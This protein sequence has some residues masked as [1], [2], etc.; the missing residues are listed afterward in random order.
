M[1]AQPSSPPRTPRT[2]RRPSMS[3]PM[4]WLSRASTHTHS[5][6]VGTPSPMRISEPKLVDDLLTTTGGPTYTHSRYG[7]LGAGATVVRTPQDALTRAILI[8]AQP[9]PSHDPPGATDD[10]VSSYGDDDEPPSPASPPLPPLPYASKSSPN[11]LP[12]EMGELLPRDAASSPPLKPSRPCPAAPVLHPVIPASPP[13][14]PILPLTVTPTP[15]Q[16]PFT[17]VLLSPVPDVLLDLS[18]L[19]VTLDSSTSSLRTTY[20]TLTSRPSHLARYLQSLARAAHE[21]EKR[22]FR[23]T[24]IEEDEELAE[25]ED[26]A[27]NLSSPNTPFASLFAAHL[28]SA[29]LFPQSGGMIHLFLDRPSA[30]YSHILTYL[31]SP[32]VN[33]TLPRSASLGSR[34]SHSPERLEV[35]LELRDEAKYLGLDELHKLCCDELRQRQGH[36]RGGGSQS[37]NSSS[38]SSQQVLV[39]PERGR[40]TTLVRLGALVRRE[41]PHSRPREEVDRASTGSSEAHVEG[42]PTAP[43]SPCSAYPLTMSPTAEGSRSRA[44]S[45]SGSLGAPHSASDWI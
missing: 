3:N 23:D 14:V 10:D 37:S 27:Y 16:P 1:I 25:D 35:L 6:S 12:S 22:K 41:V 40:D 18:S 24:L 13:A 8:Q 5:Q 9:Y 29:G 36:V 20:A 34:Q 7:P 38:S 17:P 44:Q 2:P 15:L 30:P 4:S 19:I 28:S 33:A 31:R 43:A 42:V 11:L 32:T 26:D 39:A 21:R 45:R